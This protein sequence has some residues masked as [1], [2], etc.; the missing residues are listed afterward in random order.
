MCFRNCLNIKSLDVTIIDKLLYILLLI[1]VNH[2]RFMSKCFKIW[3][4]FDQGRYWFIHCWFEGGALTLREERAPKGSN[5]FLSKVSKKGLKD[6]FRP[7]F[8][9]KNCMRRKNFGQNVAFI[10]IWEIA[11]NQF[12]RP[13]SAIT[14]FACFENPTPSK[15][16]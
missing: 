3:K 1:F 9:P 2:T 7:V 13:K 4:C 11:K 15:K 14:I 5:F 16:S 12:V 6:L 8:F 10:L